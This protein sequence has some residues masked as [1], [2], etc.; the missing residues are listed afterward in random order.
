MMLISECIFGSSLLKGKFGT[1]LLNWQNENKTWWRVK[2]ILIIEIWSH[3]HT[4]IYIIFHTIYLPIIDIFTLP[5]Y[6]GVMHTSFCLTT[7]WKIKSST[8]L[9]M[10]TWFTNLKFRICFKLVEREILINIVNFYHL[11][12]CLMCSSIPACNLSELEGLDIS[13]E[14]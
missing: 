1:E 8:T 14:K 4:H 5:W 12:C 13:K 6:G 10:G 3:T 7:V 9:S 11:A 2:Y